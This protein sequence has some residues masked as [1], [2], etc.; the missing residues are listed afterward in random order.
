MPHHKRKLQQWQLRHQWE[1]EEAEQ[2]M[3][4]GGVKSS[5]QMNTEDEQEGNLFTL[6]NDEEQTMM[7]TLS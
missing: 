5:P 4:V 1:K 2:H 7:L 6:A 3:A